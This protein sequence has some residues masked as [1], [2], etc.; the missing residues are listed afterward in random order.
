MHLSYPSQSFPTFFVFQT[1]KERES[2]VF[3]LWL[4]QGRIET[5]RG[6][7][8]ASSSRWAVSPT[9]AET[10]VS[11][12]TLFQSAGW[13]GCW[14]TNGLN[15]WMNQRIRWLEWLHAWL[16]E[17]IYE[18]VID[19]TNVRLGDQLADSIWTADVWHVFNTMWQ[20]AKHL[21]FK[22]YVYV[23]QIDESLFQF[24]PSAFE[25]K[26]KYLWTVLLDYIFIVFLW[27]NSARECNLHQARGW[28]TPPLTMKATPQGGNC[29]I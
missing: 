29:R 11:V 4:V 13:F 18:R 26:L 16:T 21:E 2:K 7:L 19:W 28:Q 1:E 23:C 9:S 20:L 22:L 15:A 8:A 17:W 5:S 27:M 24:Y 6:Q 25:K 14:L 12:S 3:L 10:S